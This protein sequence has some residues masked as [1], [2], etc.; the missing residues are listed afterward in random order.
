MDETFVP[1]ENPADPSELTQTP[2][3][4]GADQGAAETSPSRVK[5]TLKTL[6][7][8]WLGTFCLILFTL[9][10]LPEDRI[11]NYVQGMISQQLSAQGITLN[12]AQSSISIGFGI[13]YTMKD[14]TLSFPPPQEPIHI[15]QVSVSPSILAALTGK[16]GAAIQIENKGGTLH[17][18]FSTP[19]NG[20]SGPVSFS[21]NCSNLDLGSLGVLPAMASI[22]GSAVATGEGHLDGDTSLPT[23]LNG[24][25]KLDLNK[26]VIDQQTVLGFSVPRLTVSEGK[27]DI[28]ID[29]GKALI[30]TLRLGKPGSATDDIKANVT[31]DVII[32]K[33]L[34]Y[35]TLNLK[36]DF[37]LSQNVL[38]AFI[39]ID[40]L[41]GPAKQPDGSYA[42]TLTGPLNSPNAVPVSSG[43]APPAAP[44]QAAPQGQPAGAGAGH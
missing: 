25:M 39:L 36:A 19:M 44:R 15:D 22:R 34:P 5:R 28:D 38:K 6:G 9:I 13:S 35:S 1:M 41:L 4:S 33:N 17:A 18:T 11:R 31:G 14:I 21:F 37:S 29:K 42:Y 2:E 27:G 16:M 43:S 30:K 40:A 32:G 12:A 8:I 7:W 26:I 10:K 24:K 20:P 23:T 3:K